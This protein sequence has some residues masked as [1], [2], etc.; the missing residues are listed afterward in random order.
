MDHGHTGR[1]A[2]S[3]RCLHEIGDLHKAEE[4]EFAGWSGSFTG[5]GREVALVI[6]FDKYAWFDMDDWDI[7]EAFDEMYGDD[8]WEMGMEMMDEITESET[9]AIW[10]RVE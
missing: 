2:R 7:E 4:K 1:Q 9:E 5:P 3:I 8:A 6:P 10:E